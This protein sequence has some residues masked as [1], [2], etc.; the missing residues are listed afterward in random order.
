[1]PILYWDLKKR[2]TVDKKMLQT[3][4]TVHWARQ[5]FRL[6]NFYLVTWY[7]THLI[8]TSKML[9]FTSSN[10]DTISL[11]ASSPCFCCYNLLVFLLTLF[12]LHFLCGFLIHSTHSLF[13]LS[14]R[15]AD[16]FYALRGFQRD[17]VYLDSWLTNWALVYDPECGGKGGW[18]SGYQLMSS[19]VQNSLFR[20]LG[21]QLRRPG[22]QCNK[23]M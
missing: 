10:P 7:S 4:H 22:A 17:V 19:A 20:S 14:L 3:I 9:Q 15:P 12:R 1:M 23:N 21:G 8:F 18:V 2:N 6:R 11:R 13:Y 16:S 5:M